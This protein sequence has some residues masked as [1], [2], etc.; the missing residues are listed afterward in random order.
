MSR[1]AQTEV[2]FSND[3]DFQSSATTTSEKEHKQYQKKLL[4][5]ILQTDSLK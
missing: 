1:E 3:S 2:S 5:H 4:D